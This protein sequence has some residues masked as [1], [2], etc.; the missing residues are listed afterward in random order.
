MKFDQGVNFAL[1]QCYTDVP[2]IL[3]PV[4][5]IPCRVRIPYI[6]RPVDRLAHGIAG[7]IIDIVKQFALLQAI[8]QLLKR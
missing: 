5:R 6:T 8:G 4:F 2:C 3:K 7:S 1:T